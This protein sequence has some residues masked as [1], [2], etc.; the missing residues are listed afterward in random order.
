MNEMTYN[1]HP[2]ADN[3][4]AMQEGTAVSS[5]LVIGSKAALLIDAGGM[6]PNMREKVEE[7][8]KLPVT[9]TLTHAHRDHIFCLNQFES[10]CIDPADI[11]LARSGG[12]DLGDCKLIPIEEGH[13]FDL[14]DRQI[15]ALKLRGHT[16]GGLAYLDRKNRLLFSGDT[17]N[18]GPIFMFLPECDLDELIAELKRF[19]AMDTFDLIFPA[20]NRHPIGPEKIKDIIACAEAVRDGALEGTVP[21]LPMPLPPSVKV[22]MKGDCGLFI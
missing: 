2:V 5:Y 22:Y 4:W 14:G 1:I 8:T 12:T 17:I 13:I 9:V 20:H 10:A 18:L 11:P 19:D 7:L 3:V 21:Q 16:R 6:L 15:E